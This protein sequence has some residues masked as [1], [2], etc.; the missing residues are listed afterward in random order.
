MRIASAVLGASLIL[1]SYKILKELK[2]NTKW[3]ILAVVLL[4]FFIIDN[5]Y[6]DYNYVI[7]FITLLIIFLEIKYKNYGAKYNLLI[8]LLAG[9]TILFKQSTGVIIC[10]I[11][12]LYL[13][14]ED[15]NKEVLKAIMY[16]IIG[17]IIPGII[18]TI[19]LICTNSL[20]DFIDYCVFGIG[21]FTNNV[22]YMKLLQGKDLEAFLGLVTP[23][24]F[25]IL[26]IEIIINIKNKKIK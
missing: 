4:F 19:Y 18:F 5:F 25:L 2:L 6:L 23:I 8:G 17:I 20:M 13:A 9:S 10:A 24:T 16:R 11:T 3:S 15:R 14:L 1:V 12:A 7:L 26:F 21:T 22:S